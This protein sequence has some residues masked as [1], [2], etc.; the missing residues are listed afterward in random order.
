VETHPLVAP[1]PSAMR[2]GEMDNS[3]WKHHI[4]CVL[5]A[6]LEKALP[7]LAHEIDTGKSTKKM[8]RLK[9]WIVYSRLARARKNGDTA[10][11]SDAHFDYWKSDVGNAFY[12]QFT[13]RFNDWF[14]AHHKV[15]VDELGEIIRENPGF[16]RL[17]EIGCG[18]G[19][20]LRYC[21]A[22][23]S[24]VGDIVGLD[25]NPTIIERNR[26]VAQNDSITYVHGNATEWLKAHPKPGTIVLSYGGVLEYF[27]QQALRDLLALL[28][29]H[30]PAM[31]ALVEPLDPKADLD[32]QEESHTFGQEKSFSHPHRRVLESAGYA[33]RFEKEILLDGVR[34]ML[35]VGVHLGPTS[36][37]AS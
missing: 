28:A 1:C 19:Q 27:S 8:V 26:V 12:D 22:H 33:V 24:S 6:S 29:A 23:L 31:I 11:I 18:D 32:N 16:N 30:A 3:E 13:T 37:P 20:V 7:G 4:K 21:Q 34:W 9:N 17:V 14:L 36:N 25:I 5:G 2:L 15:I 10:S 35:M